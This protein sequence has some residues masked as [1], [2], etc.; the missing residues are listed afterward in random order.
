MIDLDIIIPVYNEGENILEVLDSL[1]QNVTT[2]SRILICYDHD[3]DNTLPV[4]RNIKNFPFEI[5][6][7]KNRRKG[8]HGAVTTGF[9]YSNASA[10]IVFPADDT[11]NAKIIDQMYQKFKE[12]NDI[13]AASRFMKGGCMKGCPFLKDLLVRIASFTLHYFANIPT[14]DT[15]SG[16]KLFSRKVLDNILIESTEGFTY[17]IE[18]LVK[19]HRLRW[20]IAEVPASWYERS[21]GKSR[22]YLSKWLLP[23]LRWYIYAFMTTYF[24]LPPQ[25]VRLKHKAAGQNKNAEVEFFNSFGED[26]DYDVFNEEGYKRIINEFLKYINSSREANKK[27]KICDM[28]CGTASFTSKF[29]NY[30]FELYGIDISPVC[31]NYAKKKYPTI[32][33]ATGD[34]ENT[35]YE[36]ESFDVIFLS[37]VLHHF[38]DF[39]KVL[40]ECY[41]ILKKGGI[42]LA[43]DPNKDN[44]F[45]WLYRCKDSPFY[46]SK[47]VTENEKPLSKQEIKDGL[48]GSHFLDVNI[49]SISGV[50]YKYLDNKLSF[51]IIPVY[52]FIEQLIDLTT[53]RERFG[54]FIITYGKK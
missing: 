10:V 27:L 52:N 41:R 28:G 33:F 44:P 20:R 23:Y 19:C 39:S 40:K 6:E 16:F 48:N 50:T 31:I 30:G 51:L 32:S 18:L 38:P 25:S 9:N 3:G 36:D 49:Y 24:K 54:S 1:K 35:N 11:F 34:I 53:L 4:I 46:S 8:A 42:L 45:M 26:I 21:K 5:V 43:Y 47:G 12:G 22:F 13:V 2:S 37:G 15:T 7:V 14:K 17:S 29:L